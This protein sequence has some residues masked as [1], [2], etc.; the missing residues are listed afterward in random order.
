MP[1]DDTYV[2]L[3]Q[4]AVGMTD[5]QLLTVERALEL[6]PE[7]TRDLIAGSHSAEVPRAVV[8]A[9]VR[10]ILDQHRQLQELRLDDQQ[11]VTEKRRRSV[12]NYSR[13]ALL[14]VPQAE[15]EA[16]LRDEFEWIT[17]DLV[18]EALSIAAGKD[19]DPPD[20]EQ[21][22]Y[23]LGLATAAYRR[24]IEALG[25]EQAT[26][27]LRRSWPALATTVMESYQHDVER[28]KGEARIDYVAEQ[29]PEPGTRVAFEEYVAHSEDDPNVIEAIRM[30]S[31]PD[32]VRELC[33]V[34]YRCRVQAWGQEQADTWARAEFSERQAAWLARQVDTHPVDIQPRVH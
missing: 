22:R 11:V 23:E 4:V 9:G 24:Q 17:S 32:E 7:A 27:W 21:V 14:E 1:A 26:V 30:L 13:T 34:A 20:P 10:R 8:I 2:A 12:I 25:E 29:K 6:E 28:A 33:L 5:E 3:G 16:M 15:R 18:N 31:K 19:A